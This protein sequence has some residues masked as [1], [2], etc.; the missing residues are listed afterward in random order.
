MYHLERIVHRIFE[1]NKITFTNDELHV[2]G[3][4]PNKVFYLTVKCEGYHVKAAMIDGGSRIYI[5]RLS[6]L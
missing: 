3:F 1:A 4:D 6:N 2:E 5:F